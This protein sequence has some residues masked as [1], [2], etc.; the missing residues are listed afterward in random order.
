MCQLFSVVMQ[1]IEVILH[2]L[3][4]LILPKNVLIR[5]GVFISML[6]ALAH[7]TDGV[8]GNSASSQV[9]NSLLQFGLLPFGLCA[10]YLLLSEPYLE[11]NAG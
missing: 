10:C 8:K 1:S 11:K 4:V 5:F 2:G 3:S 6:P 9:L 7:W